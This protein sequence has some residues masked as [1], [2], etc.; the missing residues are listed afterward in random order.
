MSAPAK[1]VTVSGLGLNGPDQG[2][3]TLGTPQATTTADITAS[4]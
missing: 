4:K 3:Y 1:T 2:N